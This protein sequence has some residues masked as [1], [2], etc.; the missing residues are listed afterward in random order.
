MW[1]IG[2]D[3]HPSWQQLSFFD[4]ETG[5]TGKR[6]LVN[7]RVP[8]PFSRTLRKEPALS[9]AE[10][11]GFHGRL[12]HGIFRASRPAFFITLFLYRPHRHQIAIRAIIHRQ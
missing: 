5:E 4:P 3:F 8:H 11:V 2:C 12:A 9:E 10:G 7:G 1:I 6:K